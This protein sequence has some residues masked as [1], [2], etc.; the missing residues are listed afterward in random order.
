MKCEKVL[1]RKT[2]VA[3]T[4][5]NWVAV[6]GF[7]ATCTERGC[8]DHYECT[9]C[10]AVS[11]DGESELFNTARLT[12]RAGHDWGE[13]E[14]IS[15]T[16]HARVCQT[17]ESHTG[18]ARH[19]FIGGI[20]A[21]CGYKMP[22]VTF[23]SGTVTSFGSETDNVIIHLIAE[24][25]SEADYEV[26]VQGNTATYSIGGV[27]A[28]TYT[29]KV[30]KNGHKTYTAT[31]TVSD[32][33]VIH[34]VELESIST[35]VLI[36]DVNRDGQVNSIDSNLLKRSVAGEYMID[37]ASPAALN[38]DINGD[39]QTNSIDSNLLKRMVAGEYKP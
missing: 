3:K 24:G 9:M 25:Y 7:D 28:G 26:I 2:K 39:G 5:H 31:V 12:I 22:G 4:D 6:E 29:L 15:E 8:L 37:A 33:D 1:L 30:T 13:W 17:D 36:G 23:V 35:E 32:G 20:C 21:D 10:D 38:A 19:D 16:H 27:A 34:N 18:Q 14:A 11:L